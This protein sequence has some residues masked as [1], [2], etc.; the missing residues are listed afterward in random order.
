MY[1]RQIPT[2]CQQSKAIESKTSSVPSRASFQAQPPTDI[3]LPPP[4][5]EQSIESQPIETSMPAEHYL[6]D[7]GVHRLLNNAPQLSLWLDELREIEWELD[8]GV[9]E[10][11]PYD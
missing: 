2:K 1:K 6:S 5:L 10:S 9:W 11:C 4:D 8:K 7:L 3:E